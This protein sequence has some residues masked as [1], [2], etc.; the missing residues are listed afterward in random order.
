MPD[1]TRPVP[2]VGGSL[3]FPALA[4]EARVAE[5]FT[6]ALPLPRGLLRD[7][8]EFCLL[9]GDA[10]LPMQARATSRWP[11]GSVRWLFARAQ[12]DLPGLAAKEIRWSPDTTHREMRPRPP[13]RV[14][15]SRDW[16]GLAD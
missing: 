2:P 4:T 16:S 9:D 8:A 3:R 14:S 7:P 12:V 6:L 11:D 15:P 10:H 13:P 1:Q 5:P